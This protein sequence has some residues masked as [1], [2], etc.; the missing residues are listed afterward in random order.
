MTER[1]SLFEATRMFTLSATAAGGVAFLYTPVYNYQHVF[2]NQRMLS[3][4]QLPASY[5]YAGK[6]DYFFRAGF[7]ELFRGHT[8]VIVRFAPFQAFNFTFFEGIRFKLFGNKK[9]LKSNFISGALA[10]GLAL[11]LTYPLE[12]ARFYIVQAAVKHQNIYTSTFDSLMKN[13]GSCFK[14]FAPNAASMMFFNAFYFGLFE[15][16]TPS[17]YQ[18]GKSFI[19]SYILA[20]TCV[21]LATVIHHPIEVIRLTGLQ[22]TNSDHLS[23]NVCQQGYKTVMNSFGYKGL[24]NGVTSRLFCQAPS[25]VCLVLIDYFRRTWTARV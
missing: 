12:T 6:F 23:F 2:F 4:E 13:K 10:G 15:S 11:G 19:S 3:L 20:Q 5:R 14:G 24:F 22:V 1:F 21:T 16:L 18:Q 8:N 9:N 25:A 7:K 17:E